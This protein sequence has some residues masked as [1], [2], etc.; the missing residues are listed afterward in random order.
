M[1]RTILIALIFVF[2]LGIAQ[3]QTKDKDA[4]PKEATTIISLNK[5][6]C[7]SSIPLIEK[8]LAYE[9]GVKKFEVSLEDKTVSV[10]YKT[11]ATSPERI[12]KSLAK[13]GFEANGIEAD[14]RAINKLPECCKNTARGIS[15][16]C[17]HSK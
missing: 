4:T 11:K 6:C 8:T 3:T 15:G 5:L 1:K 16:G 12:A 9:K 13:A 7:N 10:L 14:E 17:S 2:G